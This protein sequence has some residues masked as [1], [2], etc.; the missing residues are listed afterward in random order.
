[1]PLCFGDKDLVLNKLLAIKGDQKKKFCSVCWL[2]CLSNKLCAQRT[3]GQ[4]PSRNEKK[5]RKPAVL[6]FVELEEATATQSQTLKDKIE[7]SLKQQSL[8][9]TWPFSKGQIK[10]VVNIHSIQVT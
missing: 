3:I 6:G 5:Q 4:F 2:L 1:M 8:I 9:K 10:D 7:K